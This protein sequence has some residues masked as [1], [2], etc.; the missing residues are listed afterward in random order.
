MTLRWVYSLSLGLLISLALFGFMLFLISHDQIGFKET[1]DIKMVDFIR[2][3]RETQIEAKK[4]SIPDKPPPV[5]QPP[6]PKLQIHQ[7]KRVTTQTPNIDMPNLDLPVSARMNGSL[8]NGLQVLSGVGDGQ[9]AMSGELIPLVRIEPSY[10]MRAASR[11]I[12]GWVKVTFTITTEGTVKDPKV[13]D[14]KPRKIFNRNAI[15]AILKWKFKPQIEDGK[16]IE[17]LAVQT[18]EF[19]LRR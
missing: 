10:P 8:L 9:I 16:P 17:R 19:T 6:P 1:D 12:E 14:A 4:R 7:A 15:R 18:L 3:K 2:L 11:R 13:V 5:K